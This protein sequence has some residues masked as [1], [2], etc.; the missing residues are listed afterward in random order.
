MSQ[1]LLAPEIQEV[2]KS[3]EDCVA[4]AENEIADLDSARKAR[5]QQIRE[6]R[7]AIRDLSPKD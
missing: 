1:P 3:L 2:I 6:W 4:K 7:K 5:K